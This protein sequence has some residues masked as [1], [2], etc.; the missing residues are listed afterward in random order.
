MEPAIMGGKAKRIPPD[1]Q[2]L[3]VGFLAAYSKCDSPPPLASGG[4]HFAFPP[5]EAR[6]GTG[7]ALDA[8]NLIKDRNRAL[9]VAVGPSLDPSVSEDD[10]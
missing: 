10:N 8:L 9:A 7:R 4:T 5:N 1:E 3:I 2:S 6:G